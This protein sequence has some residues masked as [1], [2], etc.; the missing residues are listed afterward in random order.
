MLSAAKT[1]ICNVK[2]Q[3]IVLAWQH[4]SKK[5]ENKVS[6]LGENEIK[7]LTDL[8]QQ[9][10]DTEALLSVFFHNFIILGTAQVYFTSLS[11][12]F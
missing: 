3:K 5:Q 1:E 2:Y 11:Q 12:L 6:I 10:F 9:I 8:F 4:Q 7:K